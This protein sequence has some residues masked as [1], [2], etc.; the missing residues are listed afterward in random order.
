MFQSPQAVAQADNQVL[1]LNIPVPLT[2]GKTGL[3]GIDVPHDSQQHMTQ[4]KVPSP[5]LQSAPIFEPSVKGR[6]SQRV[7]QNFTYGS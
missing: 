3:Q 6:L 7:T 1:S 2:G 5:H 4:L